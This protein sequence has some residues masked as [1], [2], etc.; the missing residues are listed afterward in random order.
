MAALYA[1]CSL[2]ALLTATPSRQTLFFTWPGRSG[3]LPSPGDGESKARLRLA[4][5]NLGR[6]PSIP[7]LLPC[8]KWSAPW[9]RLSSN[10][11]QMLLDFF[12]FLSIKQ[13]EKIAESSVSHKQL[14]ARS[15]T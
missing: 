9:S 3:F 11:Y 4:S 5:R 6:A 8:S 1:L 2:L 15:A 10:P 13:S 14:K 7:L 12:Y